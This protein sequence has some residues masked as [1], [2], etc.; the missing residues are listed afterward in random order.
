MIPA[1]FPTAGYAGLG[2]FND[3]D[4]M[5]VSRGGMTDIERRSHFALRAVMAAPLIAGNDVRDMENA[6]VYAYMTMH[7]YLYTGTG[8]VS[9]VSRSGSLASHQPTTLHPCP[10]R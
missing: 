1:R 3:P 9:P 7:I 10:H 4:M 8:P 6:Y 2:Q 5:A